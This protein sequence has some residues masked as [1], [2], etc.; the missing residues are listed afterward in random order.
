M[1]KGLDVKTKRARNTNSM[2]RERPNRHE[3]KRHSNSMAHDSAL[4]L[5]TGARVG[6]EVNKRLFQP[7]AQLS[8]S[9]GASLDAARSLCS[10]GQLEQRQDTCLESLLRTR[11]PREIRRDTNK[12]LRRD[13][14]KIIRKQT[15]K[16]KPTE[17]AYAW[18]KDAAES[19][20]QAPSPH[21]L[22]SHARASRPQMSLFAYNAGSSLH[23]WHRGESQRKAQVSVCTQGARD[24][25][26]R[27]EMN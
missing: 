23:R 5:F 22:S 14:R 19:I 4:S 12:P 2:T 1:G 6:R 24:M 16:H 7:T 9:L 13:C 18:D 27:R 10:R 11:S 21:W 3:K 26:S 20:L 15:N 8:R 25:F 17:L